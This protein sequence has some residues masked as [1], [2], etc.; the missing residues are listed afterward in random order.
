MNKFTTGFIFITLIATAPVTALSST[1]GKAIY[2][3]SCTG[4]HGTDVFTRP[5]RRVKNMS[6]LKN[7][8]KQCSYAVE[9][10]WFDEEINAVADYLN[11][12]FYKF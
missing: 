9:A 6:K 11:K 3:K 8:V 12:D 1:N 4:C 10:K 5:D 7:R 2:N